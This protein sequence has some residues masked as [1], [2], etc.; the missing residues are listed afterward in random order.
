M[1]TGKCMECGTP[2]VWEEGK[3]CDCDDNY[4]PHCWVD[5]NDSEDCGCME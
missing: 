4:C 2:F 1:S 3:L 5:L